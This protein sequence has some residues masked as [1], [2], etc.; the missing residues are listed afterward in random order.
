MAKDVGDLT[1]IVCAA[2]EERQAKPAQRFDRFLS[3]LR[4]RP[5]A[6]ADAPDFRVERQRIVA[7]DDAV[8]SRDPVNFL[9]L[10]WVADRSNLPIHPATTRLITLN[11]RHIDAALRENPEANRLFIETLT[12]K[13]SPELTLRR[14]NEAGVLG[15][16]IPEFGRVVGMMQFSMYHHY[17]V[18]EHLIRTVGALHQIEAGRRLE[19]LPL[20]SEIMPHIPHRAALYVACFL[21]D[22]AKG[23]PEDHSIAGAAIA[24]KLCPRFGLSPADTE[25]VAWLIEQHLTMSNMAQG[26][27][28]SDPRTAEALGAAVQSVDRLK[29]LL[30]LTVCDISAVGPGVWNGWKG[31]LLRTLFWETEIVLGGGHSAAPRDARVLAAKNALRAALPDWSADE[32]AA[33]APRHYAAYWMKTDAK[34]QVAHAKLL[35]KMAADN[36]GLATSYASDAFRGI[37]EITIVAADHPRLLS[38]IAG[39]CAGAGGNIVDAQ[40]FTTTDGFAVDTMFVSR[41]FERDE[42]ELRRAQRMAETIE[43]ALRGGVWVTELVSQK[44]T[45]DPRQKAFSLLP[46]VSIDNNMSR[47]YTV[48]EVSGLDR[49]GLLHDLTAALARLN[50]NIGSA[51]I[52]TFGE[53]AVDSFYVT[54]LTG[55]KIIAPARQGAIKRQLLAAFGEGAG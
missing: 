25:R 37:T 44:A 53:K 3:R 40:V 51:H 8:F 6:M 26:R 35:R 4:R 15:R 43:Q 5:D 19:D 33:Y 32:F 55:E 36:S 9:R 11:L 7:G 13:R 27:D 20:V 49:P 16:F 48:L 31:Q 45:R 2:L 42:D 18:D 39:A 50:L 22:I 46:E 52:V 29:L 28:L 23:R 47:R 30:A 17:T 54:D 1:A 41:A 21:H 34:R 38:I 12:S 24:K 10:F 14:M